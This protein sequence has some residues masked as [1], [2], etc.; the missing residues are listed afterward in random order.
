MIVL[1]V[2]KMIVVTVVTVKIQNGLWTRK[3]KG[4]HAS[5]MFKLW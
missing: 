4:V 3:E 5:S 2:H 1:G